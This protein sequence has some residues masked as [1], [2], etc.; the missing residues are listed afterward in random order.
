MIKTE[1]PS[2]R[3]ATLGLIILI[4]GTVLFVSNP[5]AGMTWQLWVLVVLYFIAGFFQ[6][7]ALYQFAVYHEKKEQNNQ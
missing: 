7:H 3:P 5:S 1:L 4:L 2:F 6:L